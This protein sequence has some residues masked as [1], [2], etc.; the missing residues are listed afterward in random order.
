MFGLEHL[1]SRAA[2]PAQCDAENWP[3]ED[4]VKSKEQVQR[5]L[6]ELQHYSHDCPLPMQLL[7]RDGGIYCSV[8]NLY[9]EPADRGALMRLRLVSDVSLFAGE[10]ILL[11]LCWHQQM[12]ACTIRVVRVHTPCDISVDRPQLL[13]RGGGR[14]FYRA[15]PHAEIR[16]SLALGG[17]EI[18]GRLTDLSEGGLA[19]VFSQAQ[20][21]GLKKDMRFGD[22]SLRLD[23]MTL[24]VPT[25]RICSKVELGQSGCCRLGIEFI[26]L[27]ERE[28]T[29]LRKQLLS[30]QRHD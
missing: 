26:G 15:H 5:I 3:Q 29:Q 2:M 8:R 20:A 22:A 16:C 18:E 28:R 7:S 13:V 9:H 21:Q 17:S 23:A 14:E 4:L 25:L 19:V 24:I 27:G 12:Y 1:L 6:R 11:V 30:W 10:E